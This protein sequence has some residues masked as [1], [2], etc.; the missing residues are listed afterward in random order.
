MLTII[1]VQWYKQSHWR[2]VVGPS[3]AGCLVSGSS[4][5]LPRGFV[6]VMWMGSNLTHAQGNLREGLES[7]ARRCLSGEGSQSS[8]K[9]RLVDGVPREPSSGASPGEEAR[10]DVGALTPVWVLAKM[11]LLSTRV[12]VKQACMTRN[13]FD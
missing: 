5:A 11:V 7:R 6:G 9:T 4:C 2:H 10:R 3:D 8:R 12:K 13:T 1:M